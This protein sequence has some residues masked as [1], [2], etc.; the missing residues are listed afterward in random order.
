VTRRTPSQFVSELDWSSDLEQTGC[1]AATKTT[2]P[3]GF[4]LRIDLLETVFEATGTLTT[5]VDGRT[6]T[7]PANG[8]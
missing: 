2:S 7:Q 5:T 3:D 1:T 8:T 4:H 6:Y